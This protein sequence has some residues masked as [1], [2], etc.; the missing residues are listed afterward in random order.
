MWAWKA[1]GQMP[2]LIII[3]VMLMKYQIR[4][5][6]DALEIAI[7]GRLTYDDHEQFYQLVDTIEDCPGG[8]ILFDLS[9]LDFIDSAGL[10]M[11]VVAK[12]LAAA[13]ARTVEIRSAKGLV[14][15]LM[16]LVKFHEVIP[17]AD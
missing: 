1:I 9:D 2:L 8:R 14:K 4:Q 5:I 11:L 6:A 12:G 10:G 13:K 16:I 3:L 7:A 15:K 17:L